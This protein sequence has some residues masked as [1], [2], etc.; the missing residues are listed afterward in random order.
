MD[1]LTQGLL[2]AVTA[3]LGFRQK[4][5]RDATWMAAAAAVAPDLDIFVAPL[6]A[7][8]GAEM[9]G[10]EHVS[11]HRGVTHS[12]VAAPVLALAIAGL[13]WWARRRVHEAR[14]QSPGGT[15]TRPPPFRL[16]YGCTLVAVL[17]HPLLDWCTSYGTQLL[18]PFS[19]AR[20]AA[21][22]IG[23][24]DVLYTSLLL[25]TLLAC[26]IAR[27]ITG[28]VARRATR[29]VG[30]AG[31]A[32]SVAYLGAGRLL[33]DASV[34]QARAAVGEGAEIVRADAYPAVGAIFLWRTV[35]E[36]PE[37]WVVNRVRPLTGYDPRRQKRVAKQSGPW[38]ERAR[39]LPETERYAW[40]AMGRVRATHRRM[41]GQHVVE[42]H[43]MRY[44]WPLSSPESLWPLVVRFSAEGEVREVARVRRQRGGEGFGSMV[45]AMWDDVWAP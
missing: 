12:L 30:W 26:W 7:L 32:L 40:F 27:R 42:V 39:A 16:L 2:G 25:A 15:D 18:A 37:A 28:T 43:D 44:G 21:D 20:Y 3:Q 45:E 9:D 8:S 41:D 17:S 14:S 5:G 24:I 6:L 34:R 35:V 4:I 11:S 22:A 23:I 10:L 29:A 38:I 31:F 33:H 36:T 1:T 19:S 13:W